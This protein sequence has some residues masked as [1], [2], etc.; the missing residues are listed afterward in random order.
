MPYKLPYDLPY[1]LLYKLPYDLLYN[2]PQRPRQNW[3]NSTSA[4]WSRGAERADYF[5]QGP[6]GSTEDPGEVEKGRNGRRDETD[7]TGRQAIR[8]EA[9]SRRRGEHGAKEKRHER[10]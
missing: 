6:P 8:Q 5:S 2:L 7:G 3:E 10:M 4:P 9:V 1:K